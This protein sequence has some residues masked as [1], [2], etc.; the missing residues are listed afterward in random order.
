MRFIFFSIYLLVAGSLYAQN[1]NLNFDFKGPNS[2]IGSH[3]GPAGQHEFMN[4]RSN[5][6]QNV[7][8]IMR[9]EKT[10]YRPIQFY[11]LID[12]NAVK[13]KWYRTDTGK[14]LIASAGLMTAGIIMHFDTEFKVGVR[15][16]I[17]RY[18]P[19]FRDH[20]D[21]Y[22]QYIPMA[23]VFA[24]DAAGVETKH[25]QKRK[26]T[27]LATMTATSLLVVQGLKYS[28]GEPRPDGSSNNSF[29]SGHT[30][31][32]FLGAHMFHKEYKHKG[33]FYSIAAYTLASFT[34]IMRQLNNRHWISDVAMGAGLGIGITELAYFLNDRWWKGSGVREV[35]TI[36]RTINE[37][38]PSFIEVKAGYASLVN[39]TDDKNAGLQA[40]NGYR[41][42]AEG[43]YFFTRH[44]G[45]GAE[46]GFQSFP[47]SIDADVQQDF[48]DLGFDVLIQAAGN[49][50]YY[51]GGYLQIPFG[52]NSIGTKLQFG[53]ISG[54]TTKIF[55]REQ[56]ATDDLNNRPVEYVYANYEPKSSISY[57]TGLYYK[58]VLSKNLAIGVYADYSIADL[59]YDV[60]FMDDFNNGSPT[61]FPKVTET[62]NYDSYAIGANLTMMLW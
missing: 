32:A 31:T 7:E 6:G 43:A 9:A 12:S 57:A 60:T 26:F 10:D 34:G 33:P 23:A 51:G 54:S 5:A 30:T 16:D 58:R 3:L 25:S 59:K 35:D 44:I 18:L 1:E 61:Y 37:S 28:I 48:N 22:T 14:S 27:T 17:N 56:G 55:V 40:E 42:S 4:W 62:T 29:P 52:K 49:T 47:Q 20:I 50:M 11:W 15:D 2:L 41:I 21:D 13:T 53:G 45:A 36:E 19:G 8:S 39:P 38:K 46:I 24:L